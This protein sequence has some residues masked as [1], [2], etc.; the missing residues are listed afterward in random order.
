M[1]AALGSGCRQLEVVIQE[2]VHAQPVF[3]V[4][5]VLGSTL[6]IIF[7][8]LVDRFLQLRPVRRVRAVGE[9]K[10]GVRAEHYMLSIMM[11]IIWFGIGPPVGRSGKNV[12]P[13]MIA[14]WMC[15]GIKSDDWSSGPPRLGGSGLVRLNP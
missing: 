5:C 13:T 2:R 9:H 10:H 14:T 7:S 1:F 3:F 8:E 6:A 11:G 4:E 12:G 15:N